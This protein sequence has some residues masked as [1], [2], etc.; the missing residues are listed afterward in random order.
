MIATARSGLR[1]SDDPRHLS[2]KQ[3]SKT[4]LRLEKRRGALEIGFLL[5]DLSRHSRHFGFQLGQI[6]F[7]FLHAHDFQVLRFLG[8]LL[9]LQI[10]NIHRA[11][12]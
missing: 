12:P 5:F 2:L 1:R 9:R 7:E 11:S 8:L 10:L 4:S 6:G 3:S